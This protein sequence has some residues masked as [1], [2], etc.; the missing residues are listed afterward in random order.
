MEKTCILH[1]MFVL[2]GGS[3]VVCGV[4][5]DLRYVQYDAQ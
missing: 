4:S 3:A 1:K 2:M 5:Y